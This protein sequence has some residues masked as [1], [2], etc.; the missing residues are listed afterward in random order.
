MIPVCKETLSYVST[1]TA[2]YTIIP[3]AISRGSTLFIFLRKSWFLNNSRSNKKKAFESIHKY[4]MWTSLSLFSLSL[5]L[6]HYQLAQ[7]VKPYLGQFLVETNQF[8]KCFYFVFIYTRL[9]AIPITLLMWSTLSLTSCQMICITSFV[10]YN[11]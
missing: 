8:K 6:F 1:E 10:S 5:S 9:P 11:L 3:V 4:F 2:R 7:S